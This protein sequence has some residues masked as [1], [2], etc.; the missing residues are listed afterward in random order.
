[1]KKTTYKSFSMRLYFCVC[2]TTIIL[3]SCSN[4]NKMTSSKNNVVVC[5]GNYSL[6]YHNNKS[7]KGLKNCKGGIEEITLEKAIQLGRTPCSKCCR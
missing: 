3:F 4:D 5:N 2:I 6:R 7:C 1:M